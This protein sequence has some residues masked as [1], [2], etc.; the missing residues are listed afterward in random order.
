MIAIAGSYSFRRK[1]AADDLCET[2][3]FAEAAL[4]AILILWKT[5]AALSGH[6]Y[7]F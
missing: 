2:A 1:K 5:A 6:K 3:H 4:A 7:E